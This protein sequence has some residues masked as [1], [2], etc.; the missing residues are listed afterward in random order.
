VGGKV[1]R[2]KL[3]SAAQEGAMQ[4]TGAKVAV[5]QKKHHYQL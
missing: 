4:L 3:R 1:L 5:H 2:N